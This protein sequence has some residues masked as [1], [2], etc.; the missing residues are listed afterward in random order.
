MKKFIVLLSFLIIALNLVIP[1]A[2][3][4]MMMNYG[5]PSI[6]VNPTDIQQQQQDEAAG[7]KLF[8]QFQN[9]QITCQK[10]TDD[11]FEKIGEYAMSQ[12]FNGNTTAHVAM[13]QR[14]QQMRGVSGEEQMHAQF[15]R[16]V[17]GCSTV[18]SQNIT[19][20]GGGFNMMG[21][22]GYGYNGM[23][24]GNFGWFGAFAFIGWL[25]VL[26]DLILAGVWLWQ[27]IRSPKKK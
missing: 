9:S 1:Q 16:S 23:M 12:M 25:V 13:N 18:P 10:L 24:N 26:I 21:W 5:N 19:P 15:G 7:K 17:T 6:T 11:N 20:R 8:D 2:N 14:I 3:A 4:Q 27:Q 22:G